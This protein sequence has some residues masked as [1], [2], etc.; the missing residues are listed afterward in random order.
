MKCSKLIDL[1][2]RY[3][4][5]KK[6]LAGKPSSVVTE[7]M[8]RETRDEFSKKFCDALRASFTPLIKNTKEL[9]PDVLKIIEESQAKIQR[10]GLLVDE[11]AQKIMR[12]KLTLSGKYDDVSMKKKEELHK[13]M[14]ELGYDYLEMHTPIKLSAQSNEAL[15][16]IINEYRPTYGTNSVYEKALQILKSRGVM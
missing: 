5:L 9:G 4:S 14:I 6:E 16:N 8:L 7:V 15:L 3:A 10:L 12:Q 13:K 2:N 1:L 11:E